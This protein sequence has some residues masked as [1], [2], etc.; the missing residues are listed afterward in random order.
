MYIETSI[1]DGFETRKYFGI[2][3]MQTK[4]SCWS[5]HETRKIGIGLQNKLAEKLTET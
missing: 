1:L 3:N 5:W 2:Y 4:F